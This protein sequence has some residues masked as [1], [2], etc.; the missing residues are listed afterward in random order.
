MTL[1][2]ADRENPGCIIVGDSFDI[3][4]DGTLDVKDIDT[5]IAIVRQMQENIAQYK[6][7][8]SQAITEKG[9]KTEE[10]A[11]FTTMA[12]NIKKIDVGV[13]YAGIYAESDIKSYSLIE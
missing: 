9:V 3:Q 10:D 5:M 13:I 4:A 6:K 8:I 7:I 2:I 11:T 1:P 12:A